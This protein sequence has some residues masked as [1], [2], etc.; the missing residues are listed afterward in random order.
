MSKKFEDLVG[1]ATCQMRVMFRER[2]KFKVIAK[3]L[4]DFTRK[5]IAKENKIREGC[6]G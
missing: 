6:N 2:R 3:E 4:E 1:R 5:G